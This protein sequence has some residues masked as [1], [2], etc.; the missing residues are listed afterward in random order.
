MERETAGRS[1]AGAEFYRTLVRSDKGSGANPAEFMGRET[2]ILAP[3]RIDQ[4][5]VGS[6]SPDD[7]ST[8]D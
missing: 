3:T 2:A 8:V 6:L 7:V 1:H 5:S 4:K